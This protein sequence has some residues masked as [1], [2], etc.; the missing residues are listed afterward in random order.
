MKDFKNEYETFKGGAK[1]GVHPGREFHQHI[2][3]YFS[4]QI[5]DNQQVR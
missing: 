1:D 3:D 5:I 2:S 4:T